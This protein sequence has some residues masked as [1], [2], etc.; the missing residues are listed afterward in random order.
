MSLLVKGLQSYGWLNLG[1]I[2]STRTRS[3]T[4]RQKYFHTSN[5]D[6]LQLIVTLLKDLKNFLYKDLKRLKNIP[7]QKTKRNFWIRFAL[8]K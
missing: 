1:M 6:S 3:R 2:E 5:F 7:A 8:S 4:E